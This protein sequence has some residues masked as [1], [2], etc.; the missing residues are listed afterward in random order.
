MVSVMVV[1]GIAIYLITRPVKINRAIYIYMCGSSLEA[2]SGAATDN[3]REIL[4]ADIPEDTC[5]IIET[6]GCKRWWDYDIPSDKICRY[7]VVNHKLELIETKEDTCMGDEATLEDYL[8]FCMTNYPADSMGV[9]FWNHGDGSTGGVCFDAKYEY[10]NLTL[11]EMNQAFSHTMP[12]GEKLDFV[13]FDACMMANYDVMSMFS[14]YADNMIASE[15]VES[16]RGWDYGAVVENFGNNDFYS[17]VLEAYDSR[18]RDSD[19]KNY[20]LS[21]VDLTNFDKIRAVFY[22]LIESMKILSE[23]DLS[24]LMDGADSTLSFGSNSR[25][26]G[27]SDLVDLGGFAKSL[28]NDELPEIISEYV[29]EVHGEAKD[30][31]CGINIFFPLHN[32]KNL[33]EYLECLY[34]KKY[35]DF[36]YDVFV[37][38]EEP[39]RITFYSMQ[40][41]EG[42]LMA[43]FT[44][45][46]SDDI[47]KVYYTVNYVEQDK[48]KAFDG[49]ADVFLMGIDEANKINDNTFMT[50]LSG[51]WLSWNGKIIYGE[52]MDCDEDGH[53]TYVSSIRKNGVDGYGLFVFDSVNNVITIDGFMEK[54]E[55]LKSDRISE[56]EEGDEISIMSVLQDSAGENEEQYTFT[57]TG[58]EKVAWKVIPDGWYVIQMIARDHY[59]NEVASKQVAV[60]YVNGVCMEAVN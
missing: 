3:I 33:N 24:T 32:Q 41:I 17:K 60:R 6:G 37:D 4:N 48:D 19:K 22:E 21:H 51:E 52:L 28:G 47:W 27:Y 50:D 10:E 46:V 38:R 42:D 53:Y 29:N 58:E 20:T 12:S 43:R 56:L 49:S 40:V 45:E 23:S 7:R 14:K 54:L 55:Y 35:Y 39:D 2:G 15:E 26:A 9:I 30:G 44:D 57:Y 1:L 31:A 59:A 11:D 25:Y 13:G 36:L 16:S 18:Y 34:D 8:D 5:V